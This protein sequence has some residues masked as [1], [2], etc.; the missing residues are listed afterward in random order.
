MKGTKVFNING[1][2]KELSLFEKGDRVTLK[3]NSVLAIG[4]V[5]KIEENGLFVYIAWDS[6]T[7]KSK[8]GSNI[9]LGTSWLADSVKLLNGEGDI[10][11]KYNKKV[12]EI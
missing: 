11:E 3:D 6:K 1:E 7:F 5:E 10:Y 9:E 12:K 8:D 2:L 4:T